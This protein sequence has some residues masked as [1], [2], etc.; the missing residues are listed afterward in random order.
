M[1]ESFI[2]HIFEHSMQYGEESALTYPDATSHDWKTISWKQFGDQIKKVSKALLQLDVHK[3]ENIGIFSENKP[4]WSIADL[5]IM[6][7]GAVTVPIYATN[8]TSQAKYIIEEAEIRILFVGDDLQYQIALELYAQA[9]CPLEKIVI[10]NP[11]IKPSIQAAISFEE[12]VL[13]GFEISDDRT[14]QLAKSIASGDLAT[15]IYTSGTTGEPKGVM[16]THANFIQAFKIHDVRLRVDHNDHSLCFLPLSHVFERAW[17]LY[18]LYKGLKIS[19]LDDPK[20]IIETLAVVKPTVMCS[21][22]RLYQK[23]YHKILAK[24][25]ESSGIKKWLFYQATQTGLKKY[26]YNRMGKKI[27]VGLDI[28]HWLLDSVVSKKIRRVFGG[29]LRLMPCAG[30]PLS[31]EITQ[32]FHALGMPILIGYGLTE[33]CATVSV[34]PEKCF[35]FGT[36]GVA[37]PEVEIMIGDDDEILVR[38]DTIMK[39]YYKKPEA[40]AKV[41]SNGWLKTGDAGFIN[42]DGQL[43][44]TDRIKDLMKTA[45]G[46]YVAPQPIE[47]LLTNDNYIDQ[48]II[49]GDDKPYVTALLVPNFEA[50][51]EY[52]R[53]LNINYHSIEELIDTHRIKAFYEEKLENLQHSL[54]NFERVKRFHLLPHDFNMHL[55]ELTPT[56]KIRR[57]IVIDHFSTVIEAMYRLA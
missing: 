24:V 54:A 47:A 11:D 49:I 37:M 53:S 21:V 10:F 22:P 57:Q 1:S 7:I 32:F 50:L 31:G 44:I 4:E 42:K 6:N 13:S 2:R 33:T 39:G 16:L 15:I 46:K 17:S 9:N 27:P 28:K 14:D 35:Q 38:G 45:G 34:F 5:G 3:G 52:A 19:Y 20:K 30:A 29:K 26:E 55:G 48:A 25:N 8:S 43:I 40:T 51:K 36:V 12:F 18:A 41:F 23:A 56:L